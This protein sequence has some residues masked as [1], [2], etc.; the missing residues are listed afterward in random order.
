[1]SMALYPT[2][3][4]APTYYTPY[5]FPSLVTGGGDP[6]PGI[7][8]YRDRD[9]FSAVVAALKGMGEF[10]DVAFGTTLEHRA[11]GVDRTPAAVITPETWV[12]VDDVDP[13][14]IVRKVTYMLTLV[15][16]DDDPAARFDTLDRL[17][18]LAQ[19]AI[20][21]SDLGGTCLPALTL[22]RGGQFDPKSK[23]PEQAVILHGEFTTLI[24][25]MTSHDTQF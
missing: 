14:Q 6:G 19:N 5:Y 21:G 17:T 22:L 3:F 4:Y 11:A 23:F 8:P 20:D 10:A 9:T 25:S 13:A 18:S 7:S 24:P 12:E 2:R 1:M 15:V 16:R